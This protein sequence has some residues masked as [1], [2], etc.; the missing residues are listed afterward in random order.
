M[1]RNPSAK[2]KKAQPRRLRIDFE[3][4][5]A[6]EPR[7]RHPGLFPWSGG[8]PCEAPE[9]VG[10][11]AQPRIRRRLGAP[12]VTILRRV[13]ARCAHCRTVASVCQVGRSSEFFGGRFTL[14]RRTFGSTK[15]V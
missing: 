9:R 12:L 14:V 2:P 15:P 7:L 5:K 10:S 8:A 4:G 6:K 11:A 1:P 13:A 3:R